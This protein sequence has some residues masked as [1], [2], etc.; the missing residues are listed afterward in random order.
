MPALALQTVT[1]AMVAVCALG[2]VLT[3]DPLSQ[4]IAISFY[5]MLLGLMFFIY[6]A[7]DVALSQVV[8]GAVALPLMMLL[9]L[10]KM[11]RTDEEKNRQ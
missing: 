3:R 5:G 11:R 6:Q 10:A 7:P 1:L 9:A 8:I 4:S 2:V